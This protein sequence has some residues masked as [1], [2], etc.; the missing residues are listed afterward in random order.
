MHRYCVFLLQAVKLQVAPP[1]GNAAVPPSYIYPVTGKSQSPYPR[2][3]HHT[4]GRNAPP[5]VLRS[6]LRRR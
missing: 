2:P 5:F 3:A 4:A 6:V 1:S